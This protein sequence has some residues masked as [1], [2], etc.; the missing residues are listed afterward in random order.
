ME[1]EPSGDVTR[2]L[3][4]WRS[5]SDEALE[6]LMPLV[7]SELRRIAKGFLRREDADHTLQST[8][9]VHEAYFRLV[10]QKRVNWQNRA[11]FF[12]VAARMMRRILVDHARKA[13]A[14]KRGSGV[15][16]LEIDER[17]AGTGEKEFSLLALDDALHALEEL[18]PDQAKLVELRFFAGLSVEET[19][20][21]LEVSPATV[22]RHWVTAK[23]WLYR[24]LSNGGSPPGLG[25][26]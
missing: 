10:D 22:K 4:D 14:G 21:V 3:L 25:E 20:E 8:A 17:V 1:L 6:Q 19:A 2:L 15:T 7:Y 9:L 23:A 18:D 11:H 5:G 16:L 24:E 26:D 13:M 12:A